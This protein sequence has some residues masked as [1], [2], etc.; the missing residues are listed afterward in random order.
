MCI[1]SYSNRRDEIMHKYHL[2]LYVLFCLIGAGLE[3]CYGTFWSIVGIPPWIYPNSP[4]HFTS[5]EVLPLWGVGGL[6]CVSVYQTVL[7]RKAGFLLGVIPLLILAALW[8][9]IYARFIA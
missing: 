5:L 1:K 7:Q 2:L 6:I 8:I 3:W 9:L 4:V